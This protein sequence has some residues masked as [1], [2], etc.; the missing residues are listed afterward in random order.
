MAAKA[1]KGT[2][3][4]DLYSALGHLKQS[5]Q[6]ALAQEHARDVA[7]LEHRIKKDLATVAGYPALTEGP[8]VDDR[9]KR[10]PESVEV[11]DLGSTDEFARALGH[12]RHV[13]AGRPDLGFRYLEREISPLRGSGLA[14]RSMDLLLLGEDGTPILGELKR[15]PD[16][17]P[18]FALIQLLVH[19]VELSSASQRER[20]VRLGVPPEKKD[21]PMDLYLIAYGAPHVTHHHASLEATKAIAH[22]LV[23]GRRGELAQHV[24]RIAYLHAKPVQDALAFTKI[25]IAG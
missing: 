25:F 11:A 20:L 3:L 17:L 5:E 6:V 19:L 10:L 13:V 9:R 16:S 4:R 8:L 2:Q 12:D 21:G 23:T 18:H 14:R 7:M 15:G 22:H 24:R 1:F